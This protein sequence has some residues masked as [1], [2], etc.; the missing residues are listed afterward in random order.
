MSTEPE[1]KKQRVDSDAAQQT[2][3]RFFIK[4]E[5][6]KKWFACVLRG[7]G[8]SE[9]EAAG[10]AAWAALTA[11]FEVE[12]HGPRKMLSLL[13]HEFH[14]SGSCKPDVKHKW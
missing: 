3:T 12:T 8:F 5:D 11:S 7:R 10:T 9:S 6:F 13:D 4:A 14:R 1:A 2:D